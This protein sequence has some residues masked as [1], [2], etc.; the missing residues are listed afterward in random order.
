MRAARG[1]PFRCPRSRPFRRI[2]GLSA[3]R[4]LPLLRSTRTSFLVVLALGL[5]TVAL[6]DAPLR[7]KLLATDAAEVFKATE[8]A[9]TTKDVANAGTLALITHM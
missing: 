9:A 7:S 1:R 2:D 6:A 5:G 4:Y 3:P 8:D